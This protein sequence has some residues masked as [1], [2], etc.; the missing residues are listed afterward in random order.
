MQ[1]K[2]KGFR[3]N[4]NKMKYRWEE[5]INGLAQLSF[6]SFLP[7]SMTICMRGRNLYNRHGD[8][9]YW[10]TLIIRKKKERI[11]TSPID[12]AFCQRSIGEWWVY[13]FSKYAAYDPR[14]SVLMNKE[15]QDKAKETK[16]W[17]SRNSLRKW[18][19]ARVVGDFTKDKAIL[20]LNGK[21]IKETDFHF[22]TG[23]PDDY[24]S[25]ELRASGEII[26]GFSIEFGRFIFDSNPTIGE[27]MDINAWDRVLDEK[28][29]EAIT[30][31]K[32]FQLGN[33]INMTSPFHLTGPLYE[34]IEVDSEELSCA[35]PKKDI[36][37]PVRAS[38][39][40]AAGKQ[41]NRLLQNSV[42]PFFRTAEKYAAL[43]NRLEALPKTEG[44][45]DLSSAGLEAEFLFGC[46]TKR[47]WAPQHGTI[48]PM[49]L[50]WSSTE[51]SMSLV[52]QALR[53]REKKNV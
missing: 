46:P 23:F 16:A 14:W 39:L 9:S 45:K 29:M 51:Q 12:F 4:D 50:N 25:E 38:T 15:E 36:L 21:K 48:S 43:Y 30:D 32:K 42:G 11:G 31:C 49:V 2:F 17:P 24:F 8:H 47:L 33:M 13:N 44:F 7:A 20:F 52:S 35:E 6:N 40:S 5:G 1:I 3:Y 10:F 18:T 53:W 22:S 41:C 34:P 27:F 37:L 26:P 19:H 28:E